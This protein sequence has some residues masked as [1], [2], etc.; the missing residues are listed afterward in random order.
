M[1]KHVLSPD[2]ELAIMDV[3]VVL[4]DVARRHVSES[5]QNANEDLAISSDIGST[6]SA[7]RIKTQRKVNPGA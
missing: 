3:V 5:I 6:K 1:G 7:K 4:R 2:T